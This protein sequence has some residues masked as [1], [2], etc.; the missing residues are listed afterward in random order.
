[1][2]DA[3]MTIGRVLRAS[4]GSFSIGCT[5][6]IGEQDQVLPEF[7]ALV[8]A[9]ASNGNVVYGL[10]YNV[11]IEDDPF[12]RQLVAAGVQDE[13]KIEDLRQNRQVPIVVDVLVV[14]YGRGLEV[15]HRLP[16]QPPSTLDRIDACNQAEFVRFS[17]R[18]D[19]LRTIVTASEVPAEQLLA[20]ALRS[21]AQARP[22]DQR[23]GYLVNTGRELARLLAMDLPRL[24]G[25]LSLLRQ[26]E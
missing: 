4:T 14:G 11:T 25:I 7:G 15:Y 26:G 19:W 17:A 1:M 12:V 22:P 21:A 23:E 13:E 18:N 24:E 2:N 6:L 20:A 16:P 5:R 10:I 3:S 8:K 9:Q